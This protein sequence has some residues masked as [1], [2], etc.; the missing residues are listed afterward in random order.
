MR[1]ASAGSSASRWPSSTALAQQLL[2]L[3]VNGEWASAA[4]SLQG[5]AAVED[6]SPSLLA[7][8]GLACAEAGRIDAV[9]DVAARLRDDPQTARASRR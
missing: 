8:F 9:V 6:A 5:L 1:R 7:A 3:F 4:D 2:L